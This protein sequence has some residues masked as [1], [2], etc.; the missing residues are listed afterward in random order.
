MPPPSMLRMDT[1]S[2][3]D[4]GGNGNGVLNPTMSWLR[5]TIANKRNGD[6]LSKCSKRE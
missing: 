5:N 2:P 3:W 1:R 4:G 6:I